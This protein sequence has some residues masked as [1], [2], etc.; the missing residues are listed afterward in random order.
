MGS[1][2]FLARPRTVC[3]STAHLCVKRWNSTALPL[4]DKI[5]RLAS[6]TLPNRIFWEA[7]GL[8]F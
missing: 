1:G 8:I 7:V 3:M 5:E 2:E 6:H 4:G